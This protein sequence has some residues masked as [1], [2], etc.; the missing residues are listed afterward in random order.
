MVGRNTKIGNMAEVHRDVARTAEVAFAKATSAAG[1]SR[2]IVE[3]RTPH[4]HVLIM[5][6]AHEQIAARHLIALVVKRLDQE[7][8][9]QERYVSD[10]R[11]RREARRAAAQ[12]RVAL[13]RPT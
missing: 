11:V 7:Q 8:M 12:D 9:H 10:R 5:A 6:A 2:Q 3:G 4:W 1:P 13:S